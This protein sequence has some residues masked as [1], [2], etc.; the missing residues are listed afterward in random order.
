MTVRDDRGKIWRV[1]IGYPMKPAGWKPARQSPSTSAARWPRVPPPRGRGGLKQAVVDRA[2]SLLK[3]SPRT[4]HFMEGGSGVSG[5][6]WVQKKGMGNDIV[7]N[8][9]GEYSDATL[10]KVGAQL[11]REFPG[12]IY[13][14]ALD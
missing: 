1:P 5:W 14:I 9:N 13:W 12:L 10:R 2:R 8:V 4:K 3:S 11:A 6:L 7:A